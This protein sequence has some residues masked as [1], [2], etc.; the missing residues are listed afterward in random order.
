MCVHV[1]ACAHV[2]MC[3]YTGDDVRHTHC[4]SHW[5]VSTLDSEHP[6]LRG[7]GLPRLTGQERIGFTGQVHRTGVSHR[8]GAHTS[9]KCVRPETQAFVWTRTHAYAPHTQ[10]TQRTS[11]LPNRNTLTRLRSQVTQRGLPLSIL[12]AQWHTAMSSP[13]PGSL[14]PS[15][16]SLLCNPWAMA[17][18]G[19][20]TLLHDPTI[21]QQQSPQSSISSNDSMS[22]CIAAAA[23]TRGSVAA[24]S[25]A[26][27]TSPRPR[28]TTAAAAALSSSQHHRRPVAPAEPVRSPPQPT[29][30]PEHP[31]EP[32][33]LNLTPQYIR[34]CGFLLELFPHQL[35]GV[36]W[37]LRKEGRTWAER[38]EDCGYGILGDEMGLGK[39]IECIVLTLVS[40]ALDAYYHAVV[41]GGVPDPLQQSQGPTLVVVPKSVLLQWQQEI[42]NQCDLHTLGGSAQD[43]V[44]L[45]RSK[46]YHRQE[47]AEYA[48]MHPSESRR[49]TPNIQKRSAW[50]ASTI[51]AN[52]RFVLTTYNTVQCDFDLTKRSKNKQTNKQQP[53]T[54]SSED[55][56][57][58]S[59]DDEA[60][61]GQDEGGGSDDDDDRDF[62]K[63]AGSLYHIHWDRIILDEG[64]IIRN[65][66][67]STTRAAMALRG[68]RRLV[69]TGTLFN[70]RS[71]DLCTPCIFLRI[72]PYNDPK[73]WT[74]N[75]HD[76]N[77]ILTWRT[78][79]HLRRTKQLLIEQGRMKPKTI[80]TI[81]IPLSAQHQDIYTTLLR[82]S[83]ISLGPSL[84]SSASSSSSGGHKNKQRHKEKQSA[85]AKC[86]LLDWLQKLRQ[87]C[88]DPLLMFGRDATLPFSKLS[89]R[90]RRQHDNAS[91][92]CGICEKMCFGRHSRFPACGHSICMPCF[93]GTNDDADE[94]PQDDDQSSCRFCERAQKPSQKTK[95]LIKMIK[96]S[97]AFGFVPD[98]DQ[99]PVPLPASERPIQVLVISQWSSYLDLVELEL[100]RKGISH[101]RYDGD[102]VSSEARN[103]VVKDFQ[104]GHKGIQVLLL[105]VHAGGVGLNLTAASVV[106]ECDAWYNPSKSMQAIDRVHRIGQQ[107]DVHVYRL[108][109]TPCESVTRLKVLVED[110]MRRL[111][112]RKSDAIDYYEGGGGGGTGSKSSSSPPQD[113]QA[114]DVPPA[115]EHLR[116]I[117][118]QLIALRNGGERLN[119]DEDDEDGSGNEMD[120]S[121]AEEDARG[122]DLEDTQD[123]DA[124]GDTEDAEVFAEDEEEEEEEAAKH[125]A[126]IDDGD[127]DGNDAEGATDY[128]GLDDSDVEADPHAFP[129]EKPSAKRAKHRVPPVDATSSSSA[130]AS[131]TCP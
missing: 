84:S 128:R 5:T 10:P 4:R 116:G 125:A 96:Q 129:S 69:S 41:R 43:L 126:F 56:E 33:H 91:F 113:N 120:D 37:L 78:K 112:N 36:Q 29:F 64:H 16:S 66:K 76:R 83:M 44:Y 105:N 50:W 19:G 12:D 35:D 131:V 9:P 130:A 67:S 48:R 34:A 82:E 51:L 58:G 21:V 86:Q 127:G 89:R 22:M 124:R 102:I 92:S 27:S 55:D 23:G 14:P 60:D 59:S 99:H 1:R 80:E 115:D 98:M 75:Q 114:D 53:A 40:S 17:A 122:E 121:D 46:N 103:E 81:P 111:R 18:A 106:F 26:A 90:S 109:S 118:D 38:A 20:A 39:T 61:D 63:R 25:S 123:A 79:Y 85:E 104:A 45:Y 31:A 94:D 8:D 2:R 30:L 88:N 119:E 77:A 32:E 62:F 108:M 7:W 72:S 54:A 47:L 95:Y 3:V 74:N 6:L 93:E 87:V 70:N 97:L 107:R 110:F 49:A 68:K 42:R 65:L 117:F 101:Q 15:S 73:W 28:S 57:A 100:R 13:A 52:K 11:W 24:V 71:L